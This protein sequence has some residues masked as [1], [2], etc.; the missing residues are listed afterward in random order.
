MTLQYHLQIDDGDVAPYVLLPGDP[1]RVATIAFRLALLRP[2]GPV[3]WNAAY[4]RLYPGRK[5][6]DLDQHRARIRESLRRP[7]G[8][9]AFAATTHTSHAP[10]EARLGDVRARTLVVMGGRDPDFRDPTAEAAWIAER[11]RGE[12]VMVADAGHYPHAEYPEIVNPAIVRF[13]RTS[14]DRAERDS[15][16]WDPGP[17]VAPAGE[18]GTAD[19]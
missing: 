4:A 12:V 2:W 7:G 14:E 13:L 11:L 15:G 8:W 6:E 9:S 19:A 1:G 3:A 18:G 16:E 10:V 5:P 17:V